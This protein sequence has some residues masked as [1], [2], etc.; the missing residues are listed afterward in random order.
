[1]LRI[2]VALRLDNEGVY[3]DM[4]GFVIPSNDLYLLTILNS[5]VVEYVFRSVG[6]QRRGAI[7]NSKTNI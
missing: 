4:T 7:L 3:V 6:V 5:K 2:D 1:M